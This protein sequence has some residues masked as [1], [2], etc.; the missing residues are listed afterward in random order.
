MQN[1]ELRKLK[2]K[3]VTMCE[4]CE[5]KELGLSAKLIDSEKSIRGLDIQ[6]I[7]DQTEQLFRSNRKVE[8]LI[9]RH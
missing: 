2:R 4:S 5:M 7:I 3:P 8:S 6:N 9:S 1:A